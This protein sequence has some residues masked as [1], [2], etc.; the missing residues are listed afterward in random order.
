MVY[1]LHMCSNIMEKNDILNILRSKNS[2]FSFKDVLLA[3]QDKNP[4][5]LIRRLNY[6][7]KQGELYSIR[8]GFYAK[9]KNYDKFELAAKIYTPSY[10]SFETV[11]TRAGVVFQYYSQVFVA[12]YL[13][14]EIKADSQV[15]SYK[16]L[17]DPVL[18]NNAGVEYNE[19][20]SIATCE[21][22]FLDVL[23]LHKN[24]HFDNLKPLNMDKVLA[25]LP[26]YNNKR[27]EKEVKK[28]LSLG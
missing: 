13:T 15:Y 4:A 26:I 7:I 20:Y 19:N 3:S 14:R 10:I 2:V 12:S 27:M 8:R 17:K 25:I 1:S 24:Y 21:R 9:D 6:Y 22:A 11:L 18:T 5:L 16:K 28:L 23:Y